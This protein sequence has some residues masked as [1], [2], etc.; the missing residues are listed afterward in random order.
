M[1]QLQAVTGKKV[2]P[3]YKAQI[4]GR[5]PNL[6]GEYQLKENKA[7]M[8]E[9]A[10]R[11]EEA[12]AYNKKQQTTANTIGLANLGL[13][14][15]LGNESNKNLAGI[16]GGDTVKETSKGLPSLTDLG[17]KVS[18]HPYKMAGSVA[19][20]QLLGPS[21]GKSLPFGGEAEKD[22]VGS[23]LVG[24]GTG[25]LLTGDPYSAAIAGL[26]S[27]GISAVSNWFD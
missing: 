19:A 24:G 4:E 21:V 10:Q 27:A 18:A 11:E 14:A 6:L 15:Y 26:T 1:R 9:Q 2:K 7:Y 13:A 20:G 8:A 17:S 5:I 23:G 3:D 12:L 22:I 25:Y 16:L